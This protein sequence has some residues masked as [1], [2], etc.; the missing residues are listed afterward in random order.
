MAYLRNSAVNRLSINYGFYA[1]A[2]NGAW[3][4]VTVFLLKAGIPIPVV[5]GAL[6]LIVLGRFV[7]RPL[8]VILAP[9]YGLKPLLAFGTLFSGVQY[10]LIAGIHDVGPMLLAFCATAAIGEAFYWTSYHAYFAKAGDAEHRGH[11]ISAREAF[12]SGSAIAGP[13]LG[14]WA[15]THFGPQFSFGVAAAVHV[16]AALPLIGMPAVTVEREAA[17]AFRAARYGVLLFAAD[18]WIAVG[19][20]FVWQIALFVSLGESYSA[21]G[22][23]LASAAVVGAIGGLLLGRHIDGGHGGKAVWITFSAV[24]LVILFRALAT[25]DAAMAVVANA[26]GALASCLYI[27]TLMTAVYNQAKG[28]P[29]AL[30]FHAAAEGGWDIGCASGCLVAAIMTGLGAPLSSAILLSFPGVALSF[31]LLRRYYAGTGMS[32]VVGGARGVAQANRAIVPGEG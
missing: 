17:G 32:L 24:A 18:G 3:A 8:V 10:L 20:Y 16:L 11:Q 13:L 31:A 21:Y 12:A 26:L 7:I 28:S 15:L 9:R 2:A 22:G 6:A 4:F 14:G 1:L 23:V 27:P 25:H 30:R 5:F 19:Y 29:C